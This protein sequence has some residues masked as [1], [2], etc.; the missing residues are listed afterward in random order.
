MHHFPGLSIQQTPGAGRSLEG[1]LLLAQSKQVH[2]SCVVVVVIDNVCHGFVA[3]VVGGSVNAS[4][5]DTSAGQPH[6]EAIGVVIAADV[7]SF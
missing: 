4:A 5:L 2:Q 1:Q 3:D 7:F 6:T